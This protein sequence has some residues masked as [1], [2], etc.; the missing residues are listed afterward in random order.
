CNDYSGTYKINNDG[1]FAIV[2]HSWTEMACMGRPGTLEG[3][4]IKALKNASVYDLS[5]STLTLY[6]SDRRYVVKL[7]HE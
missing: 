5:E 4:F 2:W 6:D 3:R 1:S 7:N